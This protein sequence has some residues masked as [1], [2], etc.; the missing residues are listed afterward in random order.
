MDARYLNQQWETEIRMPAARFEGGGSLGQ[1]IEEFH[2]VHQ[3]LYGVKE[4]GGRLECLNWK[5]RLTAMLE[6]PTPNT[7]SAVAG[8]EP[9][10]QRTV[11]AYFGEA[12]FVDAPVYLGGDLSP[13]ATFMGPAIIEE[14]TTTVVVYPGMRA[15]VSGG[16]NYILE[17][18]V[19]ASEQVSDVDAA[20]SDELDPVQLAIMAKSRRRDTARDAG[21]RD[22]H[23]ALGGHRPVAGLFVRHRHGGKRAAGDGG[24]HPRAYFWR[25]PP[26]PNH[27][28]GSPGFPRG[29][30]L[31]S[32]RPL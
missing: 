22:A 11:R 1:L 24:R 23:R 12:G 25:S 14:P 9:S 5:A 10:A 4:E 27:V 2:E 6:R 29:R 3:R 15:S 7:E 17:P 30:R 8:A 28:P 32:Q 16:R 20:D 19:A 13:G 26:N 18:L 21:R 31:S